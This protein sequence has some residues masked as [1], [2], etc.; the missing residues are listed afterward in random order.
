MASSIETAFQQ[1]YHNEFEVK[2][3]QNGSRL[4]NLVTIRPQQTKRDFHDRIGTVAFAEKTT[5]HAPTVLTEVVHTRISVSMRDY[6]NAIPFDSE[7]KLRMN[8]NDPRMAYAE[9]QAK[10]LG[11]KLDSVIIAAATGS[12]WTGEDGTSEETYSASTYGVAVNAVAPGAVAADSNLTIEKLIQARSKLYTAE[13]VMDGEPLA[14]VVCQNQLDALLRI[15]ELQNIDTNEVRALVRGTINTY[16][17]FT[18]VRVA[19][20]LLAKDASNVRTCLAFPKSAI[21]VGMADERT[22]KIDQRS[23]LNYTWQVWTQGT[24]GAA[25]TW[26]EKVVSIACDEDL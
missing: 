6:N 15:A 18:F 7:D 26:R 13:A 19:T 3:Q 4:R 23:D 22:T 14:C 24:F 25:R 12:T 2:F 10:A 8:L 21:V 1:S 11:R 5:R 20:E 9:T 17:G 16:M